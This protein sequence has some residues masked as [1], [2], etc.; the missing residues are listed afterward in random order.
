MTFKQARKRETGTKLG[1]AD[2]VQLNKSRRVA[3]SNGAIVTETALKEAMM[4]YEK[5]M[6][7]PRPVD[8]LDKFENAYGLTSAVNSV[9]KL[10]LLCHKT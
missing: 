4:V 10:Y 1:Q 5:L 7:D 2:V 6:I 8:I 9:S 3:E